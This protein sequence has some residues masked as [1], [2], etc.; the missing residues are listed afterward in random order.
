MLSLFACSH[1]HDAQRLAEALA[2]NLKG[3]AGNV[4]VAVVGEAAAPQRAVVEAGLACLPGVQLMHA[5]TGLEGVRMVHSERPDFVLLHMRLGDISCLEVVRM[6]NKKI[7]GSPSGC[8]GAT[9]P[10]GLGDV[11][12]RPFL[13]T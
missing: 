7:G 10:A 13:S 5:A 9:R 4:G 1:A 6:R 11:F 8:F 3:S 12:R 2:H